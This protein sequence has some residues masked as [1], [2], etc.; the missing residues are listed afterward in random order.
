MS[1][2][3]HVKGFQT[4]NGV[5]AWL[6]VWGEVKTCMLSSWC[7]C[8]S[9]SRTSV[10][11]SWFTPLIPAHLG[12]L[13][14]PDKGPLNWCCCCCSCSWG[15]CHALLMSGWWHVFVGRSCNKSDTAAH[16]WH[17]LKL[18]LC[19][20]ETDRWISRILKDC[21]IASAIFR[22]DELSLCILDALFFT[23]WT[24]QLLCD[25]YW[26]NDSVILGN[27]TFAIKS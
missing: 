11:P 26:V 19:Q 23:E 13:L 9:L 24:W 21:I 14:V 20:T 15:S 27:W 22:Y 2:A 1:L 3:L 6:S 10:N 8:H 16:L 7:H 25:F 5:L 4:P 12:S 18:I 17:R